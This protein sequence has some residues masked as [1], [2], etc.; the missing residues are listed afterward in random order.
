MLEPQAAQ[1][2]NNGARQIGM[3]LYATNLG[4]NRAGHE[5]HHERRRHVVH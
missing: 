5:P 4:A 3:Q 2:G 1:L